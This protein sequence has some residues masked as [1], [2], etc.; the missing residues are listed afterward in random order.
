[1]DGNNIPDDYW[2]L[3]G[4]MYTYIFIELTKMGIDVAGES[5]L[6]GYPTQF[7]D[8]SMVNW[9]TGKPNARYSTLKLLK[10]NFG[11]GDKLVVTVMNNADLISQ[12][13]IT[14]TAKKILLVNARNKESKIN[15][16]AEADGGL[17]STVGK[18]NEDNNI[19]QTK[20]AGA[21]VTLKPFAVAV[22]QLK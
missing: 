9:N 2:N 16:P 5:Q 19:V 11:P 14:A 4:A 18:S 12:A 17:I 8:V 20:L 13:F 21:A 1:M 22:I 10:D 7:P 15:L 6:V 3:S